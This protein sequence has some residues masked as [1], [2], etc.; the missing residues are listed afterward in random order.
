MMPKLYTSPSLLPPGRLWSLVMF[1]GAVHNISGEADI[2][3]SDTTQCT[4]LQISILF[5][6]IQIVN[7]NYSDNNKTKVHVLR[8]CYTD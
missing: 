5:N 6:V 2:Y 4:D 3:Q 1:S 7:S 8:R